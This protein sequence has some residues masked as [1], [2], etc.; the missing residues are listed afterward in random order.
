ME[1]GLA[2]T[3]ADDDTVEFWDRADFRT[4]GTATDEFLR[5]R[6]VDALSPIRADRTSDY[7]KFRYD[8]RLSATES[9]VTVN[10][11]GKQ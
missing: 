11:D 4:S 9:L 10:A 6:A 2:S 8:G 3:R 5:R 1:H 7:D